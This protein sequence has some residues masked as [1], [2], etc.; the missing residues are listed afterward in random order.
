MNR[1]RA[2]IALF[3]LAMLAGCSGDGGTTARVPSR[4][5][6]AA[7]TAWDV[8]TGTPGPDGRLPLPAALSAFVMAVGPVPGAPAVA[9][10]SGPID[11][12]SLAVSSVLSRWNELSAAQRAAVRTALGA[13]KDR[14]APAAYR[15]APT[16]AT[17]PNLPCLT[18]DST[19]AAPYR[20]QIAGILGDLTAR[21]SR[22]LR[23][24]GRLFLSIN[25]KNLEGPSR[26]YTVPCQD[27]NGDRVDGCTIHLNPRAIGGAY[28]A[29]E[30]HSFLVHE[31]VHCYLFDRFGL[32]Y[33]AMPAW[34]VEGAPTWAMSDLGPSS[35]RLGGI[36]Q[37]YLDTPAKPLSARTYDGLGFFVHLAESG[38][39][40]WTLIDPIGAALVG[41]ATPAGWAAAAPTAGFVDS[42][43]SGFAQGRYPGRAWTSTGPSLPPY[44][45]A[46][47][48]GRLGDGQSLTVTA[49]AYA[50]AARRID[51]DAEIVTITPS[52]GTT[53]R[54]SIGGG[55]DAPLTGGPFCT[56]GSCACPGAART[57]PPMASGLT[58]LGASA[59]NRAASVALHGS[60]LA[61]ACAKPR[62][63][64]LVGNWTA[65]GY[66]ISAGGLTE[67]G[68]AGVKLTIAASG[69]ARVVYDGMAPV[70]FHG[71][72]SGT[73]IFRGSTTGA[74]RLPPAG[75]TTGR[76]EVSKVGGIDGITADVTVTAPVK[77][78]MHNL[79]V[80]RL[81]R[82]F[83]GMSAPQ[84]T[85]GS[86]RCTGDTLIST[87]PAGSWSFTREH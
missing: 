43:G 72:V 55:K 37:Q 20:A 36:W 22:P 27:G 78:T 68:G 44:Q 13:P 30:L 46:L 29:A 31:I 5:G 85:V 21:L 50:A 53:G 10:P 14:N 83:A 15:Q 38:A 45:P 52:A 86:W 8:V 9:G 33:S 7:R 26:M 70:R 1:M 74:L 66:D 12:A 40:V 47:P 6:P 69:A 19:G 4:V 76:W 51:V 25:T 57:F 80:G 84:L 42:W 87:A 65:T 62:T 77:T 67:S 61:E 11:S 18:A 24:A 79:A 3:V 82:S 71:R 54:I 73:L 39:R 49:P 32:S 16:A 35:G 48:D 63:A 75:A 23:N 81:A 41:H 2:A 34:Y 17:N 56:R 64:C 59:G 58:F 60:T 28:T